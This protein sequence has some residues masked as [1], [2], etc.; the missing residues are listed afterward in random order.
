MVDH[1]MFLFAPIVMLFAWMP[2][3]EIQVVTS[4]LA[5]L[6]GLYMALWIPTNVATGTKDPG[7]FIL[8]FVFVVCSFYRV[9]SDTIGFQGELQTILLSF[10]LTVFGVVLL[11]S[12][13]G[14]RRAPRAKNSIALTKKICSD[15]GE[16]PVWQSWPKD[17]EFPKGW[18]FEP[19]FGNEK[20]WPFGAWPEG[21]NS[22]QPSQDLIDAAAEE[23]RREI[24]RFFSLS[25]L[26]FGLFALIVGLVVAVIFV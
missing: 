19:P 24:P 21:P 18:W 17:R 20:A 12:I 25:L 23:M 4:G 8:C 3:P 14:I 9:F 16:G 6:C 1:F 13:N 2:W 5:C 11:L 10:N 7:P 15:I 22:A 26:L